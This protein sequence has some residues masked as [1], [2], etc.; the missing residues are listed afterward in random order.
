MRSMLNTSPTMKKCAQ[1]PTNG[2][3]LCSRLFTPYA[4]SAPTTAVPRKYSDASR[5]DAVAVVPQSQVQQ[6][7][8]EPPPVPTA[9]DVVFDVRSQNHP[10]EE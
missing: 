9:S 4:A 1:S 10:V 6:P 2:P 7:V 8:Q 5:A 3:E